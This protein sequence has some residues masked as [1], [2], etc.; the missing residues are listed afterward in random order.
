[1]HTYGW[2]MR[3]FIA[4]TRSKD[5]TPI[6]LSGGEWAAE[7][8]RAERAPFADVAHARQRRGGIQCAVVVAGLKA[9]PG[10]LF[11]GYLAAKGAAV[12]PKR[13]AGVVLIGDSTVRN[14]RGDGRNGQWGWGGTAHRD[15][16]A[17]S[18]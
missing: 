16:G 3:R 2:Y 10:N 18:R 12:E 15:D 8:A 4:E 7:V 6:V 9:L 13:R 17:K 1:V 14:G 5:A 11:G